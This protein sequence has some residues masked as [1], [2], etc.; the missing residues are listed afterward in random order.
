MGLFKIPVG[1]NT[2]FPYT[3]VTRLPHILILQSLN[4]RRTNFHRNY[5]K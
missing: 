1:R 5:E 4:K 3:P 2:E